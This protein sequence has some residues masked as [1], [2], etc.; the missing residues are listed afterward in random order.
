MRFVP[1][2]QRGR[3]FPKSHHSLRSP[4]RHCFAVTGLLRRETSD[5]RRNENR[6]GWKRA[7]CGRR[8]RTSPKEKK[9][10]KQSIYILIKVM[11]P[12]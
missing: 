2:Y 12:K 9:E 1:F 6:N 3:Q 10:K 5:N 11:E 4:E 8:L 7:L